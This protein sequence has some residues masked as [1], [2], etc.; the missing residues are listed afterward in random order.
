MNKTILHTAIATLGFALLACACWIAA[1]ALSDRMVQ[2]ELA[3]SMRAERRMAA[4][5]VDNTAQIIASDLAMSRA[6]PATIAE[7]DMVQLALVASQ[8]YAANVAPTDP[9]RR[10][11]WLV[12]PP[13]LRIDRF[14]SNAR[15]Y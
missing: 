4:S 8:N 6:I 5:I 2:Q 11:K 14:L 3:N 15:G 13:L 9:G 7:M 10:A 1:G 12:D